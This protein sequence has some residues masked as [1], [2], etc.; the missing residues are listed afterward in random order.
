MYSRLD[1]KSNSKFSS[2][3]S[4]INKIKY[5]EEYGGDRN[6]D[7]Y[8]DE[9][10]LINIDVNELFENSDLVVDQI[11][12]SAKKEIKQSNTFNDKSLKV[13]NNKPKTFLD[14]LFEYNEEDIKPSKANKE[15]PG[16]YCPDTETK[17]LNS[18]QSTNSNNFLNKFPNF[19]NI[20]DL[21]NLIPDF[22][23]YSGFN[24]NFMGYNYN[25]LDSEL[26]PEGNIKINH[27]VSFNN[28]NFYG[29]I[30]NPNTNIFNKKFSHMNPYSNE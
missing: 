13:I 23:E 18:N 17:I 28:N 6:I 7:S 12:Q 30:N 29:N 3:T 9:R 25:N 15:K 1:K 10:K 26:Y 11:I 22:L 4:N 27:P 2:K 16:Y 24:P 8:I 14:E 5:Q 20:P 21:F 19:P